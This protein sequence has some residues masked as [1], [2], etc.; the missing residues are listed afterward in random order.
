MSRS[1]ILR[2]LLPRRV[3]EKQ[4]DQGND[5]LHILV[6][7]RR[8]IGKP[9]SLIWQHCGGVS[10]TLVMTIKVPNYLSA[11]SQGGSE[12][13]GRMWLAIL[14]CRRRARTLR[15]SNT[16]EICSRSSSLY[17]QKSVTVERLSDGL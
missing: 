3:R 11:L 6:I 1:A 5:Q 2:A 12:D 4:R 9:R 8:L 10:A 16:V 13:P 15:L 17:S 14:F 7:R